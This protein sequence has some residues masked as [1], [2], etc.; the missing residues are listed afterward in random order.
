MLQANKYKNPFCKILSLKNYCR[1]SLLL[2]T[3]LWDS[4]TYVSSNGT[5][6]KLCDTPVPTGWAGW[7]AKGRLYYTLEQK[8]SHCMII[9][10]QKDPRTVC[11]SGQ[12]SR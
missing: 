6:A 8:S 11:L 12:D 5:L 7:G 9:E 1:Y 10:V 4:L 3:E 2:H